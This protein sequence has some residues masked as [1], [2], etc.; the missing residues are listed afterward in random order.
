[1]EDITIVS[2]NVNGLNISTKRRIIF[3][4]LRK[5][6]A[7]I[8]LIQETH[9]TSSTEHLWQQEWGGQAFFSNGSKSSRG[10]AVLLNRNLPFKYTNLR[11]DGDGR[12]LRLDLEINEVTYTIASLYAPTQDKGKEQISFLDSVDEFLSETQATNIIIG[13]DL[14]HC[15][16]PAL[17]RSTN[18]HP[19][20]ANEVGLKIGALMEEWDL[21][22]VWRIR[23]PTAKGFTFR[24]GAY[25]SR[26]DYILVS[27]HLSDSIKTS[28]VKM[29]PHSDHALVT[30]SLGRAEIN[31]GPG[32]WRLDTSL[33]KLS[34]YT[35]SM[36]NFLSEWSPPQELTN[37]NSI[38]EWLKFEI[39]TFTTKFTKQRHSEEKQRISDLNKELEQLYNNMD[40][41]KGDESMAIDSVRRELREIEEARARKIIF[42]AK[43]NWALYGERPSKYFLNLEK[44]KNKANTLH[45]LITNNGTVLTKSEEILNEGRTFYSELYQDEEDF[46]LPMTEVQEQIAQLEIPRL[47]ELDRDSMDAPFSEDELKKALGHLNTGKTPGSDGLPPE[48]FSMFWQ[49]LAPYYC[50]SLDHSIQMGSMSVSQRRGLITLVP[51]KGED[52]RYISNWRPITLLNTDYKIYT[53][54][55]AL[56]LGRVMDLLVHE[57]QTGF[58]R[59]RLIGDSVRAA[60]DSMEII[61]D[62][63]QDGM[64]VALDFKK[65]FDSVRWSLI[66]QALEAFNFGESFIEYVKILFINIQSSLY[67]AGRTSSPFSPRRGI[68]QGCCV[69]P[70]LF[71]LVVELLAI[72]VR[73]NPQIKGLDFRSSELK[74][75]QFADDA[76]CF[77]ASSASLQHLMDSLA[78]FASWSGLRVNKNKTKIIAPGLLANKTSNICGMPVVEKVK[79]L[80]I[81]V[82]L[83]NTEENAYDW[84]FKDQLDKIRTV[85]DSWGHRNLSLKG[86]IIVANALLISLLQYPSSVTF[87]PKRVLKDYGRIVSDFIWNGRRPKISHSSLTQTIERGGLKLLDLSIR[88]E[89]NMLQ[90]IRRVIKKPTMN[91]GKALAV[92][93]KSDDIV[94]FLAYR[95]P[96]FNIPQ[97]QF[98][99]YREMLATWYKYRQFS[100]ETESAIRR[101][102][103]WFNTK[104]GPKNSHI[105]WRVWQNH[106]IETIGDICHHSQDRLLSHVEI[107]DKFGVPCTFLEV[108]GL[109]ANIPIEWRRSISRNW[110]PDK[111]DV[112]FQLKLDSDP[113]EDLSILG[114]KRMYTKILTN[115][116]KTNAAL[117]RW[118]E[119]DDGLQLRNKT[120]WA[121]ACTRAFQSTRE[122]KI[123]SFQYKLLNRLLP[124]NTFLK[125]LR[126]SETDLC[127]TCQ[128]RDSVAHFL[129]GCKKVKPFWDA[130]CTWFRNADNVYLDNLS[131]QEMVFGIPKEHHKSQIINT[132]LI[133]IRYYIHRQKLFHNGKMDLTQWLREFRTKLKVEEWIARRLGKTKQFSIWTP[134]LKTMG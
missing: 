37:P 5:T 129:F 102:P 76:T 19:P 101:E 33:L 86:K 39:Q 53:K 88:V 98:R 125:R 91:T 36:S 49:F 65:A 126:I 55:L 40:A 109:R 30:V 131:V 54:A 111:S 34:D 12:L 2:M 61:K 107:A 69:S 84:N 120:E 132:I 130:I 15:L 60:E 20:L 99:F 94:Q 59:G 78:L 44:R 122:T 96:Q 64:L 117:C 35:S 23:N 105:H 21:C 100:P 25:A 115:T 16:F 3:D 123:Q 113:P 52:R 87:T 82:G 118:L 51:K 95:N 133:H 124:C 68:R 14:N 134:I 121:D 114:P 119:G 41:G 22:D 63:F 112:G 32:L 110:Q 83:D 42:R 104:I 85:C 97:G 77:L 26:L 4:H 93:V 67:N 116:Q 62:R 57:N 66:F 127:D 47:S 17:D 46:L 128:V 106:G 10:V 43:S 70:F 28:D 6:K 75:V 108:L 50:A 7:D 8:I 45:S 38:W 9:A 92:I 79:I 24:R 29:T 58:M 11:R 81:W 80:G 13:G 27:S 31:R 18:V 72:L 73:A 56:R 74:I 48:F 90:W 89:V 71:L 1:M 103:L